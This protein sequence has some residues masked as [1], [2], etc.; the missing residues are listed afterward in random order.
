VGIEYARTRFLIGCV[1][2][3]VS[4]FPSGS[5]ADDKKTALVIIDMQ[6]GVVAGSGYDKSAENQKKLNR[7]IQA[8]VEAINLAKAAGAPIIFIEYERSGSTNDALKNAVKGYGDAVVFLKSSDGMFDPLNSHKA[9]LVQYLGKKRIRTL[10]IAGANGGAC[11]LASIKGALM[12]DYNVIAYPNGIADFNYKDFIYPYKYGAISDLCPD[13]HCRNCSFIQ[14]G[15]LDGIFPS[16]NGGEIS[17][18]GEEVISDLREQVDKVVRE[19]ARKPERER[20]GYE[21]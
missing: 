3:L 10:V 16:D 15:H 8:Q 6:P 13:C 2:V 5:L 21:R 14:V 12:R 11:V 4:L 20:R 17:T 7:L 9:K 19:P 1:L 18:P